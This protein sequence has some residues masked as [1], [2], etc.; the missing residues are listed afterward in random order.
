MKRSVGTVASLSVG[1]VLAAIV[2]F[3]DSAAAQQ[4]AFAV[5]TIRPSA[6]AVQFDRDGKTEITPGMLRMQDVTV[7]TCIKWAYGVQNSQIVGPDWLRSEHFDIVAKADGPARDNEMKLMMQGLLAER[8]KLSFHHENKESKAFAMTVAKGGRKLH[9][10]VGEGKPTRQNTAVGVVAKSTSMG[11][12]ADFISGPLQTH[13]VDETGLTGRY[14]LVLDFTSY[15]PEDPSARKAQTSGIIIA[16]LRGEL[17]LKLESRKSEVQVMVVD[18][19]E[20]PSQN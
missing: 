7:N 5:A 16:A 4:Q 6:E 15:F 9:E 19:V 13:V 18:H 20:K 2:L 17:G 8:F 12:F 1:L 3:V 11:E 14:D 10:S